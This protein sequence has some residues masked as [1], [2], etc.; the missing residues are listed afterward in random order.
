MKSYF[1]VFSVLDNLSAI[2]KDCVKVRLVVYFII[3]FIFCGVLEKV[4]F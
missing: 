2:F 4:F 3:Y 1:K